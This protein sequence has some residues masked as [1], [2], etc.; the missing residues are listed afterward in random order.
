MSAVIR[1]G[2]SSF[3][4]F[5]HPI[6]HTLGPYKNHKNQPKSLKDKNGNEIHKTHSAFNPRAFSSS[7][8]G[9]YS[10]PCFAQTPALSC[11]LAPNN[12]AFTPSKKT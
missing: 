8:H 9:L 7:V 2:L 5:T 12:A 10:P 11:P 4:W 3:Q 6:P 1:H